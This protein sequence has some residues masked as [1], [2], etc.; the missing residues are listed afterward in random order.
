[1]GLTRREAAARLMEH[2]C[3]DSAHGYSQPARDGSGSEDVNL[4]D[5][6]HVTIKGGDRDCSSAIISVL[7][8]VGINTYGATYT[9]NMRGQLT[10]GGQFYV[11][12]NIAS[13]ERGDIY[14]NDSHHTAMCLGGGKL[15]EFSISE[16]GG[17]SGRQGDQTGWESHIRR[18]YRYSKGWNCVLRW[19]NDGGTIGGSS[20]S[21]S[22]SSSSASGVYDASYRGWWRVISPD[23]VNV[24]TAPGLSGPIECTFAKG[25]K[26]WLDAWRT[27]VDNW[28]WGKYTGTVTGRTFY[29]AVGHPTGKLEPTDLLRKI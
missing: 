14:L 23:G 9:G 25:K 29:V 20:S 12:N 19:A 10:R 1:M 17:V 8:A 18:Y 22:S 15:G 13:A 7:K 3:T 5:G 27:T 28:I 26:V 6:V 4:G 24:R 11:S 2:L 21:S 16:T